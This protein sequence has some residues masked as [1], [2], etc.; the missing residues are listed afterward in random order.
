MSKVDKDPGTRGGQPEGIR[1]TIQGIS[2]GSVDFW[3]GDVGTDPPNEMGPGK[4]STQGRTA[5]H[6][7][8]SKETG[9]GG[10]G[11]STA[12]DSNGGGRIQVDWG[13]HLKE[14]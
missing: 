4:F 13:L 2:E 12:V 9:G 6:R 5:D 1:D 7:E 10:L 8:T 3:V 14:E 11:L